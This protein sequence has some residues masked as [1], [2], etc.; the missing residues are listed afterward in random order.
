MKKISLFL[1]ICALFSVLYLSVQ[2]TYS[3]YVKTVNKSITLTTTK[4]EATFLPGSD[5][6]AKIKQIAG[7]S[8][9]TIETLDTNITSIQRSNVL[10][11]I[12]TENNLVS[13]SDSPFPIY[14]WFSNGTI[15]YY[16]EVEHPY[17]N[18]TSNVMFYKLSNLV[19]ID[20]S[21]IDTSRTTNMRSMFILLQN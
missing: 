18:I 8:G 15:Y 16:T 7:N 1:I 2:G 20:L 21:T 4:L 14:A 12:P 17:M 9:A 5:F 6:N 19:S 13:T 10:T 11:I 3:I